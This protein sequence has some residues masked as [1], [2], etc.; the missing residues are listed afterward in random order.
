[1]KEEKVLHILCVLNHMDFGGIEAVV[2]NYYRNMDKSKIQFDFAV[3]EES[4]LPQRNEIEKSEG[5]IY[6]LPK[7]AH[8][9]QYNNVLR[10]IMKEKKYEIVH[11]HM[12]TLSVF[13]LFS[14]FFAGTRVRICHNHSTADKGEGGKTLLKYFLRPFNKVFATDYFACGEHAAR[15]MYGNRTYNA[16]KVHVMP[17]AI[18]VD[19][20]R[21]NFDGRNQ[22]RKKLGISDKFVIGH[23]GRFM[24]QKNHEFLIEIYAEIHRQKK[25]TVL[26][27]VGEGELECR[28]RDKVRRLG[29]EDSVI[30]YGVSDT[31]NQLYQV[32][33]AFVF[34]SFYEGLGLVAI[35]AQ[36][37]GLPVYASDAVPKEVKVT[38]AF[39]YMALTETAKVWAAEILKT[40]VDE[41]YREDAWRLVDKSIY[42]LKQQ[43][44][45]EQQYLCDLAEKRGRK[46]SS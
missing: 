46:G 7:I 34:P 9:L 30:F 16:G 35:E 43:A 37:A 14:A 33:D 13:P 18:E 4:V 2:M 25:D 12:N 19:R 28:I 6:L 44:V 15:W 5:R 23:I 29:L 22:L 3:C 11:C 27:L 39:R 45:I 20:F 17:N 36:A 1:M 10:K 8:L 31:V 40:A 41:E 42:S 24:Y 38:P 26:L 21:Y 32:M